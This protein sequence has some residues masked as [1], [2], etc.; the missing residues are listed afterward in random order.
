VTT[1]YLLALVPLI[2]GLKTWRVDLAMESGK[3]NIV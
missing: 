3:Q 1:V 2:C